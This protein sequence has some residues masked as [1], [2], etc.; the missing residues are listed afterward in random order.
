MDKIK[1]RAFLKMPSIEQLH[2]NLMFAQ[3]KEMSDKNVS[4]YTERLMRQQRQ[5]QTEEV[6]KILNHPRISGFLKK[7]RET[8]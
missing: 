1:R 2:A 4:V 7:G 5:R 6:I 3:I 8:D